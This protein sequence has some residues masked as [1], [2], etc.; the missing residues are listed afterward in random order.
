[1]TALARLLSSIKRRVPP[2]L[3]G[4]GLMMFAAMMSMTMATIAKDLVQELPVFEVVFFRQLFGTLLLAPV[5]FRPGVNPLRT[6]R[7]GMHGLRALFNF[8]AILGYFTSLGLVPLAQI[9]ALGF[10]S[11]VFASLLA[12]LV[13]GEAVRT[14]RMVGLLLGFA[15]ALIILRP[16]FETVSAGSLY[17]LGSAASWA[18]A[19]TCIKALSRTET[20]VAI[21]FYAAFL[22]LPMALV[23][24][25]FVW[26]WP[27]PGQLGLLLVIS[28]IGT[29]AQISLSQAFREADSTVVL[30]MD[31]TKLVWASLLGYAVFAEIP[32]PWAWIGGL[33]VFSGVLWVA[34]SERRR[35]VAD[36]GE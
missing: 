4:M 26:Q 34:Y 5:L 30:P 27:S 16:G 13:L 10:T 35:R 7:I 14:P 22:Q 23:A 17:V 24:A 28:A 33:V 18:V 1:M 8:V 29:L 12:V 21:T 25:L 31:F 9:T 36:G 15:G 6:H 19:M 3:R 2:P 20:S 11:P 32:D